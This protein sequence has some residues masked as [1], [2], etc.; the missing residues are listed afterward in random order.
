MKILYPLLI[1]VVCL[2]FRNSST[3]QMR[4]LSVDADD[5]NEVQEFSFYSPSEGY[6]AFTKY[7]GFTTDSGRTFTRKF[8]T[9][10]NVNFNNYQVNLTFGFGIE[11]IVAFNQDTIIVYG[12]YGLVPSILY[13]TD[14]GNSFTL[15][16]HNRYD[17]FSFKSG[18]TSMVFPQDHTIGYAVDADR[19]LKTTNRGLSWFGV[20][21]DVNRYYDHVVAVDN[22]NVFA[23]STDYNYNKLFKTNNGG[24]TWTELRV[25]AGQISYAHFL[26]A[27]KG[28]LIMK[29]ADQNG[30]V[31]YTSNGGITWEQKNDPEITP[32][33]SHKFRFVNDS[34][35]YGIVG[36]FNVYKTTDSG[37]VWQALPRDNNYSYLYYSY[38]DIQV[39]NANQLWAGG[40]HGF[41]EINTNG[42]GNPLPTAYF[43]VDTNGVAATGQ[44]NLR[45]YSKPTYQYKWFKNDTLFSTSYHTSFNHHNIYQFR[46]TIKLV[47]SDGTFTDTMVK[48]INYPRVWITSFTPTSAAQGNVVTING[49]NFSGAFHVSFGGV[50]ASS[51]TVISNTQIR[52]TVGSGSSGN[53]E[54]MTVQDGSALKGGFNYLG[55]PNVT[56]PSAI[57]DSI[58]CKS[59]SITVTIQN[60]EP[61][62]LYKLAASGFGA[63]VTGSATGNGG[64]V[65]FVTSPISESGQYRVLA[66]RIGDPVSYGFRALFNIK[67]EHTRARFV[68]DQVNI[69]PGETVSYAAQAGDARDYLW[70]F[71]QD[72]NTVT[73]TGAKI[74]G[75]SYGSSGQ[76]TLQLIS[77]SENGCRDTAN[78]NSVFVYTSAGTN[79]SCFINP[80]DST[81]ATGMAAGQ[82]MNGLNDDIFIIGATTSAPKLRSMIGVGKAFA[83]GNHSFLAKYNAGGVLKWVHYFKPGTGEIRAGQT[84]AQGNIYLTGY[85]LSTQWLYFNNGDSMQFYAAPVDT[86]YLGARTNGFILKLDRNGNYIWHTILYDHITLWQGYAANASGEQIAINDDNIIVIAG[87][88][89]KISYARN[90]VIQSLYDIPSDI[91]QHKNHA[92]LKIKPDGTLLWNA[93]LRFEAN[94]WHRLADVSV[95]KAGNSYLVGTYEEYVGIYDA[96]GVERVKLQGQVA[97]HKAFMV[98]YNMAGGID[99]H[100][101]FVSSHQYGDARLT[102][103]F[104]DDDGNTYVGGEMFNWGQPVSISITH[105][106]GTVAKDSL[107]AFALYKFD[108]NGKRRWGVGSRYPYYGGASAL[109]A[110]GNE[111]YAA[112]QLYNNGVP[113]STFELTSSD[114]NTKTLV[115]NQGECY[116]AKYDTAGIFKRV[117]TSG[118][119]YHGA[120]VS[121]TSLY[122]NSKD[123][124]IIGANAR[125]S[126]GGDVHDIFGITWP[127]PFQY[128]TDGFFVKMQPDFCKPVVTANAGPDK[129]GCTGD[130]VSLGSRAS[131]DYYSW[132][133]NP[134][135]FTSNLPN[136]VPKPLVNTTYYLKVTNEEG[137]IAYDTVS[138]TLKPAPYVNAGNDT[139]F[140]PSRGAAIGTPA[141]AGYTYQWYLS[142][143]NS[144]IGSGIAQ[145]TVYPNFTTSY[146]LRAMGPN[147]CPAYDTITVTPLYNAPVVQ[148]QT[149]S[150]TVCKG[151]P[152]V[153]TAVTQNV[154]PTPTYQWKVWNVKVGANSSTYTTDSIK[155]G[156]YVSV[157]VTHNNVCYSQP[158][159]GASV[160]PLK[161]VD[162]LNPAIVVTG[163]TTVTEGDLTV[164]SAGVSNAG[165][166]YQLK[167]QDSTST[168][169]WQDLPAQQVAGTYSYKPVTTGD[170]IR[171]VLTVSGSCFAVNVV[172]SAGLSFIVN[173]ITGIEPVPGAQYGM[174]YYPNPVQS[175]L[176]IDSLRLS[177]RWQRLQVTGID[178]RQT[179]ISMDINNRTRVE[180]A[181]EGLTPGMYVAIIRNSNGLAVYLKFIK[182]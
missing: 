110:K 142:S 40:G 82:V 175:T 28:W 109:Y 180:V 16:Y 70:T 12:D 112:G 126:I 179:F 111:V 166:N 135:G 76:K 176:I 49:M 98:K 178:G 27:A 130:T 120:W 167:W 88:Y 170:K 20:K 85:A 7:I 155:N 4:Q 83:P 119:N 19:I 2:V 25:P 15:V 35:G 21:L 46:D 115:I 91:K 143:L 17:V 139:T 36:L 105:S 24:N 133:S 121:P 69:T 22:D 53:I 32:F 108:T 160:G 71:N 95:D 60:S 80:M 154:G 73:A 47:V 30:V 99:W 150:T 84:D 118:W 11:G 33:Y 79:A 124:V 161:V 81:G 58:L 41:V 102:K 162:V 39:L 10:N 157:D 149:P 48:Y 138:V 182:L 145:I 144:P 156:D 164:I 114:G 66:N 64:T 116:V 37:K 68:A 74:A 42:T 123:Q 174:R 117:Y 43:K 31:Y 18:I 129:L 113:L 90:G 52:A 153:F 141:T 165:A 146:I 132:T 147:G 34:T 89:S 152:V 75:I 61:G 107:A 23:F 50:A 181:A 77:I 92:V 8:I 59:E 169:G 9:F 159:V 63:T 3:A 57:S 136:P 125:K 163:N 173:K 44:V 140:C 131:G 134:A 86:T 158:T 62:V 87:F 94:N 122:M 148:I 45:N 14:K 55:V 151:T 6:V 51:F 127:N 171:C 101:N 26:T 96:S 5:M 13:S 103:V 97:Y 56:L 100:N 93:V 29:N 172:N 106:D 104:A 168:H 67:V 78:S 72:A 54:V 65:S 1:L 38:N 177:D 137:A 128:L